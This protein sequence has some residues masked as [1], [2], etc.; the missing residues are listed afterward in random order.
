MEVIKEAISN[1]NTVLK[2]EN[3]YY[4]Y[5]FTLEKFLKQN[6]GIGDFI[7]EEGMKWINYTSS[8]PK[9]V[10]EAS[11]SPED[12]SVNFSNLSVDDTFKLLK[13]IKK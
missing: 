4:S 13:E 1:Y 12:D 10:T 9:P 2:D 5:K 3:Y 6:N 8:K 11:I 7:S